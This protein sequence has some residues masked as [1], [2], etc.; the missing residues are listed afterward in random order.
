M[1]VAT[2]GKPT[3]ADDIE[4]GSEEDDDEEIVWQ[5]RSGIIGDKR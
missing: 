3:E 2:G 1:R 4:S 5:P